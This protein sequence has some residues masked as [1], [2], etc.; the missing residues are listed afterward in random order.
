[1]AR[2]TATAAI[3]FAKIFAI[4]EQL[5]QGVTTSD[6]SAAR[7]LEHAPDRAP[8]APASTDA[9]DIAADLGEPTPSDAPALQLVPPLSE[10]T[11]GRPSGRP[12]VP[13]PD[14]E[15]G[16]AQATDVLRVGVSRALHEKLRALA[17][18]DGRSTP[19]FVRDLLHRTPTVDP[20]AALT[21]LQRSAREAAPMTTSR[22]VVEVRMQVP[23]SETL[24]ARLHQLAALRGQ[25]LS[26]C[27][28]DVLAAAVRT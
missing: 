10:P 17:A 20:S 3:D 9:P 2:K 13:P 8:I 25:T 24:H 1:M 12:A 26:A 6:L 15:A 28:V 14:A 11:F 4:K 27:L 16:V 18:L 19:Q 21:D 23:M 5:A 22:A 7:P